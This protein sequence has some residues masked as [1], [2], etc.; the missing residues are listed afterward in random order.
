[1]GFSQHTYPGVQLFS[2]QG[3]ERADPGVEF[4]IY[5]KLHVFARSRFMVESIECVGKA[6][7]YGRK[8]EVSARGRS[9]QNILTLYGQ[10]ARAHQLRES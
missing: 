8:A 3:S 1:M 6:R 4:P 2:R 10:E 9:S 5:S 7:D